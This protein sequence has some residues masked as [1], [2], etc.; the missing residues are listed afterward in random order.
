M[1]K[2]PV[3][4]SVRGSCPHL[5]LDSKRQIFWLE[6]I[7]PALII[8]QGTKSVIAESAQVNMGTDFLSQ[9]A[10]EDICHAQITTF[11]TIEN[12]A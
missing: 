11:S 8:N 12:S 5:P 4:D 6:S 7:T 2:R 9:M 3:L 1:G 10:D